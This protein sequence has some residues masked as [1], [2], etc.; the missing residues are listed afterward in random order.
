[1]VPGGA[2]RPGGADRPTTSS[3]ASAPTTTPRGSASGRCR[4]STTATPASATRCTRARTRC[5]AAGCG[6]PSRSTAGGSTSRTCSAA[7]APTSSAPRSRAA[8][9]TAVKEENPEAYLLGEHSFD[10][11]EQLAG[12]QWDGVMNYAGFQAPVLGWLNGARVRQPRG[13]HHPARRTATSTADMVETLDA[14]RAAMP[15]AVARCQYNLLDSH[16]TARIRTTRRRRS[17]AAS[18]PRFGL[19]LTYVGVPVDPV[20]RR[21]RARGHGRAEHAPDDA[22][23]PGGVGS[24]A[25]GLRPDARPAPDRVAGT[26][27]RRVPGPRGRRRTASPSSATRTTSRSIVVVARGPGRGRRPVAPSRAG[28]VADGTTSSSCSAAPRRQSRRP[29]P[30]PLD[31]A[32]GRHLD[33]HGRATAVTTPVRPRRR[34]S[35]RRLGRLRLRHARDRRPPARPAPGRP[36]RACTTPTTSSRRTHDPER[37]RLTVASASG[38]SSTPTT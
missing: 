2:G 21:D 18:V 32:R 29:P 17:R 3:S 25:A 38:P 24:R 5:S 15:W 20:R 1:M 31:G 37:C 4:S 28:A 23:G 6:R 14:F 35:R 22:L 12:D 16:D 33:R 7:S 26:P 8:S 27:G 34:P 11:T 30:G 10:A 9:A 19:L 13:R 36:R